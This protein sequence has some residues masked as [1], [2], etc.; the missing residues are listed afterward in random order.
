MRCVWKVLASLTLHQFIIPKEGYAQC[1]WHVQFY[2]WTD[3]GPGSQYTLISVNCTG[4]TV[5]GKVQRLKCIQHFYCYKSA[6]PSP[7]PPLI[8][9]G[10]SWE[11]IC[12]VQRISNLLV[13]NSIFFGSVKQ[14]T[15]FPKA[16]YCTLYAHHVH[17]LRLAIFFLLKINKSIAS[18][19]VSRLQL[20]SF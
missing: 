9:E 14:Y 20:K 11:N 17:L 19:I 8:T 15:S 12:I 6:P 10:I 2:L 18:F 13:P 7:C 4:R 5:Y 16:P 1:W 3:G